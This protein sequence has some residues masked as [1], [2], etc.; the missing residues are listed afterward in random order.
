MAENYTPTGATAAAIERFTSAE[1]ATGTFGTM[2]RTF[3]TEIADRT[4]FLATTG[5]IAF[6]ATQVTS[7][8]ANTLDDYEEGTWTPALTF[9]GGS[10]GITYSVQLGRYTKIGRI[11]H[12]QFRITLSAKGSSTGAAVLNGLPFT[13]VNSTAGAAPFALRVSSLGFVTHPQLNATNNA[14]TATF[15]ESATAGAAADIDDTD[16]AANTTVIG[17]S[18]YE[19]A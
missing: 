15:V 17:Q 1:A 12:V 16:F 18:T 8:D 5:L 13:V 2:M 3:H 9:G 10:T 6:P 14:T 7:A 19:V 4:R 11:V